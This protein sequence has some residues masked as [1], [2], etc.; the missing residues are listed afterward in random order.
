MKKR[1]ATWKGLALL[2]VGLGL[3]WGNVET[4]QAQISIVVSKNAKLDS[5]DVKKA[6]LKAI[7]TGNQLKWSNGNK[8][9]VVD[10][11][12]TSL[13][14]KFYDLVL[15]K[16]LNQVRSQWTKLMLSGQASAPVQ[17]VSD[18]AVKKIVAN[19]PYALGYIASSAVDESVKELF[20]IAVK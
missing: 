17:C 3:G 16:T 7:Y 8:I 9:Q 11:A 12:E 15:G 14:K 4:A 5:N 2:L 1:F 20:R 10:Q 19:N 18:K 13:G 6:G